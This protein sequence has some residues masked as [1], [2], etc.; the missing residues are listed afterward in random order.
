MISE[1]DGVTECAV[2]G[3]PDER[4]GEAVVAYLRVDDGTDSDDLVARVEQHCRSKL[5]RFKVP[6]SFELVDQLP[7]SATGKVA[8]GRLRATEAR[9]A[10]GLS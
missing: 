4:A 6:G 3:R 10:M 9:R 5:A 7:R 2:I 8:K 1:V